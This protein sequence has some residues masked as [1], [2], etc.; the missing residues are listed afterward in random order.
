MDPQIATVLG[1]NHDVTSTRHL[2]ARG[3]ARRDIDHA[4]RT[5][6]LVRVRRNALVRGSTWRESAPWERHALRARAVMAGASRGNAVVLTHHSA[7]ALHGI[8]LHDV[9]DRVH[10]ARTDT[11]R[12]RSD[13]VVCSHRHVPESQVTTVGVV[14]VA[15]VAA[16][17]LQVAAQSGVESGLVSLDD[18]LHRRL[19][20]WTDVESAF[21]DLKLA[22]WS[23]AARQVM[24]L[25]DGRTESA[26]E[27][28]ARWA[29]HTLGFRQPTPQVEIHDG[30]GVFV[31]RVDFLYEDLKLIVEVDGLG[32][33][34]SPQDLVAEKLR[35]DRLR[36]LGYAVVRLTWADLDD[37]VVVQR[38]VLDGVGRAA[39]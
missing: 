30:D 19:C 24:A 31:A 2:L 9:D 38:K 18:A 25:A 37:H 6:G 16:A 21:T 39:A 11:T 1:T 5:G 3:V 10:L 23:R 35:E 17:C 7:L 29:F 22:T 8:S 13:A 28:R 14:R 34:R 27:S 20:R 33:Y 4:L 36:E 26:A 15:T 32:K 12:G